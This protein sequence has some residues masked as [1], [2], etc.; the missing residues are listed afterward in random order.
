MPDPKAEL[1]D[2]VRVL[3]LIAEGKTVAEIAREMRV[4]QYAVRAHVRFAL[5]ELEAVNRPHAV[6]IAFREGLLR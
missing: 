5:A 1:G 3:R 2:A 4:T 6:A